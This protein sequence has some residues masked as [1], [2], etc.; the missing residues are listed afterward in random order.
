MQPKDLRRSARGRTDAKAS[1]AETLALMKDRRTKNAEIARE[2]EGEASTDEEGEASGGS[3][4]GG[5]GGGGG[6][7][8][9]ARELE[10]DYGFDADEDDQEASHKE[11]LTMQV[12]NNLVVLCMHVS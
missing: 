6:G 7:I 12:R 4:G 10:D 5:G 8:D 2:L 1:K 11:V 9:I 3:E